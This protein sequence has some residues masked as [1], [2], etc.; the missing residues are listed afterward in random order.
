MSRAYTIT[1]HITPDRRPDLQATFQRCG[2]QAHC[3]SQSKRGDT[4]QTV[5][6]VT[7]SAP[8]QEQAIAALY[9]DPDVLEFES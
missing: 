6:Q 2:L 4:M 8:G 5:W 9:G 7:G 3:D 1:T